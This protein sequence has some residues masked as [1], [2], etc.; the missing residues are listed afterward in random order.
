MKAVDYF[1][2]AQDDPVFRHQKLGDLRYLRTVTLGLLVFVAVLAGSTAIYLGWEE[3]WRAA[4]DGVSQLWFSVILLTA[5]NYSRFNTLVIALEAMN[6]P[7]QTGTTLK[8]R[9]PATP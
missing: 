3:G 1:R 7:V 9:C 6:P 8:P 2:R 5:W 4:V